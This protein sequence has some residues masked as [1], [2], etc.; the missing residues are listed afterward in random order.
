MFYPL[1][2]NNNFRGYYEQNLIET[3]SIGFEHFFRGEKGNNS[4]YSLSK[5]YIK[6]FINPTDWGLDPNRPRK[7]LGYPKMDFTLGL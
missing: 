4:S 3:R 6:K 7:M 5:V 2:G 1:K